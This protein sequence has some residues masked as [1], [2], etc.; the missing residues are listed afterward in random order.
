MQQVLINNQASNIFFVPYKGYGTM[1]LKEDDAFSDYNA[2]QV[3]FRHT[4]GHGLS[5]QMAYTWARTLDD[6]NMHRWYATSDLN[7]TQVFVTNYV[8]PMPFFKN[9]ASAL[10]SNAKFQSR[11]LPRSN[12]SGL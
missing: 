12:R 4:F 1:E 5:I 2:L 7:R 8:Y 11:S 3:E 10:A 6:S 9:A